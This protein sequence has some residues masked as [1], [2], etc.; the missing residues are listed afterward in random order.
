MAFT[1]T[2]SDEGL[3]VRPLVVLIYGEPGLGKTSLAFTANN[4][5]LLDFDQGVQ[6]A[7]GRKTTVGFKCWKDVLD[8]ISGGH[9]DDLKPDTVICDTAG[10]MLDDYLADYACEQNDANKQ[11]G[12]GLSMKGYGAIKDLFKQFVMI[13]LRKRG[14]DLVI[15]AHQADKD[16]GEGVRLVPKVTGGSYD[17][18]KAKADLVGFI[19]NRGDKK[20][21]NFNPTQRS[22][23]KNCAEFPELEIPHYSDAKFSNFL[24]NV[25]Q[26]TKDH[27]SKQSEEMSEAI[28]IVTEKNQLLSK[29]ETYE[30]LDVIMESITDL[31]ATH[32]VAIQKVYFEKWI[33][34]W[35]KQ[36]VEPAKTAEE[37]NGLIDKCKNEVPKRLQMSVS[38]GIIKSAEEKGLS[39]NKKEKTFE[40]E[41][42]VEGNEQNDTVKTEQNGAS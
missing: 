29:C 19:S 6:R 37:Y 28:K 27:M 26:Q 42:K 14:I 20:L 39:F 34:I 5:I 40:Q 11:R 32:K 35:N 8:F 7:V 38:L 15:I 41:E 21:I 12:G 4:P 3:P 24:G 17:I 22:I 25:I 23:G 1:I 10:T 13:E 2:K 36:N 18:L 9:L 33:E 30:D 31:S 16:D